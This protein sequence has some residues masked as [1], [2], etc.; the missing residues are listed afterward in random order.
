MFNIEPKTVELD[1]VDCTDHTFVVSCGF[2]LRPLRD[3]L[4]TLGLLSPPLLRQLPNGSRQIICGYQ[5]VMVLA[6]LGWP[7]FPALV[8][9]A[10]TPD[11]RCLLASLHDNYLG[12]GFNPLEAARMIDRLLQHFDSDT[13]CR[14]YLPPLGLPPSPKH[15]G[16]YRSL[17]SLEAAY[18]DLV[19]QRRLVVEAAA[20]LSQWTALDR[21][22]LLPLL[23]GL[24]FSHSSQL[25]IVEFLTTLSRRHGSS[26][27]F[28]LEHPELQS[29]LQDA[30][31]SAPEKINRIIH[32]FRQWCFPR[33]SR[34]QQ[35]FD[36]HLKALGLYHHPEVRL[37]PPP[38]FESSSFRLEVRFQNQAQLRRLLHH[39]QELS[40]W[41]ELKAILSL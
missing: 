13:V 16:K 34:A 39:L 8:W 37:I 21:A 25:E 15:L 30:S 17:L 23:H 32:R 1:S 18:Q 7:T 10:D 41:Q 40:Q 26:P 27:A 6:E 11:V 24:A 3:S 9:P 14:I 2:D 20:L 22:A 19:A 5:R 36:D 4:Q 31:L 28:W 35:Q 33:A 38:A 12:R 29:L